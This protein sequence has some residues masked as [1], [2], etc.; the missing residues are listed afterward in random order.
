MKAVVD[1]KVSEPLPAAEDRVIPPVANRLVMLPPAVG[2]PAESSVS[3]NRY[4]FSPGAYD[5]LSHDNLTDAIG[6][7][8][9]VNSSGDETT[10]RVEKS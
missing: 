4:A 2:L 5:A 9:T 7:F 1:V 6:L 10:A 8:V 3:T